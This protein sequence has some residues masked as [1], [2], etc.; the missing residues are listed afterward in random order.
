M[1]ER[2]SRSLTCRRTQWSTGASQ[3]SWHG[4]GACRLACDFDASPTRHCNSAMIGPTTSRRS[5][6]VDAARLKNISV[7]AGLEDDTLETIAKL[8][9]EV[10]VPAGKELVRE[11]DFSY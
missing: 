1:S 4:W 5:L 7:F 9:S 11:G 8:A 10:S 3:R 6:F 2:S